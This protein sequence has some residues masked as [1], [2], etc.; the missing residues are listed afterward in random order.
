MSIKAQV[1]YVV[2]S[3]GPTWLLPVALYARLAFVAA[4]LVMVAL[5][6]PEGKVAGAALGGL[7]GVVVARVLISR[8]VQRDSSAE[9]AE[10]D[11]AGDD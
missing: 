5:W 10:G 1:D 7:V 8:F 3:K 4:V 9:E 2:S 11:D 6:V